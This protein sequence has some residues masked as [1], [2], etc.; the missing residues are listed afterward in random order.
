MSMFSKT[1]TY[2]IIAIFAFLVILGVILPR[3][4]Q[5]QRKKNQV[6]LK[7]EMPTP[8][9]QVIRASIEFPGNIQSMD[10]DTSDYQVNGETCELS[11][12]SSIIC[13]DELGQQISFERLTDLSSTASYREV[14]YT[15]SDMASKTIQMAMPAGQQLYSAASLAQM[16][17]NGLFTA[18]IDSAQLS[19]FLKDGTYT[20]MIHGPNGVSTHAGFKKIP[21]LNGFNPAAIATIAFQAMAMISGNHYMHLINQRLNS[22]EGSVQEIMTYHTDHDLGILTHAQRKL[23]DITAHST[24][25][26]RDMDDIHDII[27]DVGILYDHYKIMYSQQKKAIW[28]YRAEKGPADKRMNSYYSEVNRFI[29][30][31]KVCAA[32]Y[33]IYLQTVLTEIC[34]FLKR[35]GQKAELENM[36]NDAASI[37]NIRFEASGAQYDWIQTKAQKIL[38]EK[39]FME[40]IMGIS[41]DKKRQLMTPAKQSSTSLQKYMNEVA[42]TGS[43]EVLIQNMLERKQMLLIPGEHGSQPRIFI[44]VSS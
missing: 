33:Q 37:C 38:D 19:H 35:D 44:P 10:T 29:A 31:A 23:I 32:A 24:V 43:S 7:R 30:T 8:E 26:Q 11:E 25:T 22:I 9:Q 34:L 6:N 18:T 15:A 5:S 40:N 17:P 14:T 20:T 3:V 21:G 42:D 12:V 13:M 1:D 27:K 41:D 39:I 16:A 4:Q 28:E 2:T 36:I